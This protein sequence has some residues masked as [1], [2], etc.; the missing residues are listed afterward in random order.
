MASRNFNY[1]GRMLITQECI[2]ARLSEILQ[3][4]KPPLL[5]IEFDWEM[6][7]PLME[8]PSDAEVYVDV[9]KDMS[10][11]RF[12][13]GRFGNPSSPDNVSLSELDSWTSAS[14]VVRIV[15][16][17][18]ILGASKKHSVSIAQPDLK[19]RR[20]LIIADYEDLGERPWKLDVYEDIPL[21]RLVFN[22]KWWNAAMDSSKPLQK[23]SKVMGM[24]MPSVFEGMLN[25]F[26]INLKS[27]L[28]RWYEDP[29]W[30][31]AW[32]R[33]ARTL[34]PE[35]PPPDYVDNETDDAEFLRD[36][37]EWIGNVVANYSESKALSS[38]LIDL[39]GAE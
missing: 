23:D 21:P 37:T 34:L 5:E 11:M 20:S 38:N 2:D 22:E 1:T 9:W 19:S 26:I 25:F 32:I 14:F 33:F 18:I 10:F 29:S 24:I 17:G 31:G 30:K 3:G 28:H 16:N 39:G 6:K 27:D 13:Y 35:N 15:K 36:A 8:I 12:D 7:P 4:Q